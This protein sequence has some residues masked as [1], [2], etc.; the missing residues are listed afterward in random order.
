MWAGEGWC[1]SSCFVLSCL[2]L[3]RPYHTGECRHRTSGSVQKV[4][5]RTDLEGKKGRGISKGT[6]ETRG[7][8]YLGSQWR[9]NISRRHFTAPNAAGTEN[10]HWLHSAEQQEQKSHG[11]IKQFYCPGEN[12]TRARS[13]LGVSGTVRESGQGLQH[14]NMESRQLKSNSTGIPLCS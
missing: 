10:E 5:D 12:R 13:V 8:W 11:E 7:V 6:E 2:L 3:P 1:F 14:R 4:L 9:K